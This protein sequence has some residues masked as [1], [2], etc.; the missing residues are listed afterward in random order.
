M[1]SYLASSKEAARMDEGGVNW[2][3]YHLAIV[4]D[5]DD[6]DEAAVAAA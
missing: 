2:L 5:A 1:E 6:G 4:A 3:Q